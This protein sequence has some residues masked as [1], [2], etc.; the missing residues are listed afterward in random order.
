MIGFYL[1][2]LELYKTKNYYYYI[3]CYRYQNFSHCKLATIGTLKQ[4]AMDSIRGLCAASL[5]LTKLKSSTLQGKLIQLIVC[6]NCAIIH[7]DS[8]KYLGVLFGT[9]LFFQSLKML[10][11]VHTY[12]NRT[13]YIFFVHQRVGQLSE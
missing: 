1:L 7:N 2:H 11:L 3:F 6:T 4:P 10:G 12:W 13:I 5:I 8:V 9:T